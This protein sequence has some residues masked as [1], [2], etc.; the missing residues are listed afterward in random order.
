MCGWWRRRC[1]DSH[2]RL[3]ERGEETQKEQRE[4]EATNRDD[5]WEAEEDC[6]CVCVLMR[7]CS[8][9]ECV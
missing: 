2:I 1:E 9:S 5:R 4:E 7:A 6:V 3:E 8:W